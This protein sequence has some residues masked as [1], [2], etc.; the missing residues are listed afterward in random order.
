MKQERRRAVYD[1]A[2]QM[3]AYRFQGIAQPFPNH[4][5]E[6]YVLGLVEDGQRLLRCKNQV[7]TIQRG[8]I[9]LFNPGDNHACTQSDEGTLD[10]LGLT[11]PK[12]TMLALAFEVTGRRELPGFTRSVVQDEEIAC[13]LRT[14]HGQIMCGE[15]CGNFEKEETALLLLSELLQG[16]GQPFTCCVP[17]CP[18]EIERAC[19][20]MQA[21]YREKLTLAEIACCANLSKSTLLRAFTKAKGI[22]PYRYLETVR[23][24]AAK[25]LLAQ[26]VPPL[27]AALQTGFADQS[28]FTNYF[29]NYIGLTPGVYRA[30]FTGGKENGLS[31]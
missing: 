28:H 26:G 12:D 9:L 4:F 3:E 15:A 29:S 20:F 19:A 17:E 11:I 22:T 21:H 14:L 25:A 24:N 1:A 7:Y 27:D 23:I 16:Y 6:H 8:S 31:E 18:H 5:H 2:L 10:Y 30:I 13:S